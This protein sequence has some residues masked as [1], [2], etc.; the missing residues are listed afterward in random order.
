LPDLPFAESLPQDARYRDMCIAGA[1]LKQND[2]DDKTGIVKSAPDIPPYVYVPSCDSYYGYCESYPEVAYDSYYPESIPESFSQFTE[3]FTGKVSGAKPPRGQCMPI[4][5]TPI[6]S[7]EN[8]KYDLNL[9]FSYFLNTDNRPFN[10]EKRGYLG[11]TFFVGGA[12]SCPNIIT[13][14]DNAFFDNTKNWDIP[15][16]THYYRYIADNCYNFYILNRSKTPWF[17]LERPSASGTDDPVSIEDPE[18]SF[19]SSCQPLVNGKSAKEIEEQLWLTDSE[20][21][22]KGLAKEKESGF[23]TVLRYN[24]ADMDEDEYLLGTYLRS[25][26]NENFINIQNH[27]DN[28]GLDGEPIYKLADGINLPNPFNNATIVGLPCVKPGNSAGTFRPPPAQTQAPAGRPPT[29]SEIESLRSLVQRGESNPCP[30][31]ESYPEAYPESYPEAYPESYPEAYPDYCGFTQFPVP[32]DHFYNPL[33]ATSP[34][35]CPNVEKITEPSHPF[36][37]RNDVDNPYSPHTTDR[38]YSLDTSMMV[39]LNTCNETYPARRGYTDYND[40]DRI[41]AEANLPPLPDGTAQSGDYQLRYPVVQCAIVPVDILSFRSA[42]FNNC[43]SQRITINYNAWLKQWKDTGVAPPP[44]NAKTGSGWQP[45]CKTHFWETDSVA[46]CPVKMSIQQCCRIIVKDVVPANFL[47]LRTCQGLEQNRAGTDIFQADDENIQRDLRLMFGLT[48]PEDMEPPPTR[49][50]YGVP[51]NSITVTPG[52]PPGAPDIVT[53]LKFTHVTNDSFDA[54]GDGILEFAGG[55]GNLWKTNLAWRANLA[56]NRLRCN[57]TEPNAYRFDHYQFNKNFPQEFRS[58]YPSVKPHNGGPPPNDQPPPPEANTFVGLRMPYMRWWDTGVSAGN[59]RRGGSFVNT[60]GGFDTFIGVG[61]EERDETTAKMLKERIEKLE[62]EHNGGYGPG[63]GP[64]GGYGADEWELIDG[65][66]ERLGTLQRTEMGRVGG[67]SELKAHQM[68]GIRRN[69]LFCVGR[70][71]KLF[72]PGGPENFALAKSGAGYTSRVSKQWPWSLGWRGYVT[73]TNPTTVFPMFGGGSP[74][75]GLIDT[76]ENNPA[77]G[78]GKGL[79]NAMEGD[80]IIYRINGLQQ[81]AYVTKLGWPIDPVRS[82]AE[83]DYTINKY[84]LNGEI[85]LPDRIFVESWD[86]GKFP[87]STGS[88]LYWGYGPERT[89]YK[90]FVPENYRMEICNKT[91]RALTDY[92]PI[93]ADETQAEDCRDKMALISGQCLDEFGNSAYC[94]L[95]TADCNSFRCQPSCADPDYSACVLPNGIDDWNT[96]KIYRPKKDIRDLCKNGI[97]TYP[98]GSNFSLV[99]TYDISQ[100]ADPTKPTVTRLS[101]IYQ[102]DTQKINTDLWAWCVNSGYDPPGHFAAQYFGAQTGAYTDTTLCG[103]KWK[104]CSTAKPGERKFFPEKDRTLDPDPDDFPNN[105]Q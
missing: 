31:P 10:D 78:G 64:G 52:S 86:Q 103:P 68:W 55:Y 20:E 61:R 90:Y 51:P 65:L 100:I 53:L 94:E 50:A 75:D 89:I 93:G 74:A 72:K 18:R 6:T 47:K 33:R 82:G 13:P 44:F 92:T 23:A 42:A 7:V 96:A 43:I 2:F 87:T 25:A 41:E 95:T 67:W 101:V 71:E 91:I 27:P 8:Y 79:D 35:Y 81:I 99:D 85:L 30:Y 9:A 70:Y 19:L 60:L 73:D 77:N 102:G 58:P 22:L 36:S 76:S 11:T 1:D 69:N 104:D 12:L 4:K 14:I 98:Q 80:I 59:P 40:P 84:K 39:P 49:A 54:N 62:E 29:T 83:F 24:R 15:K 32:G 21:I 16:Y 56:L 37:P 5:D 97:I 57:E 26:W 34:Y 46:T 17:T 63:P 105:P 88:S 48:L 28:R 66:K 3:H 45:P 38:E